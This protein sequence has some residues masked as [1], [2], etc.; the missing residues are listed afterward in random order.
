MKTSLG[1]YASIARTGLYVALGGAL[2]YMAYRSNLLGLS[3]KLLEGA[4]GAAN[5]VAGSVGNAAS[6]VKDY[7]DNGTGKLL[8]WAGGN[9]NSIEATSAY[10]IIRQRD[11]D[12]NWR[13]K[14]YAYQA[15]VQ[16]HPA[17]EAIL[18]AYVLNGMGLKPSL[19]TAVKAV[20]AVAVFANGEVKNV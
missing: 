17:N 11:F 6:G 2:V 20:N 15:A 13:I 14:D 1:D 18:K 16:A 7:W 19:Q 12:S 5:S 3:G 4:A 10:I 9:G 8:L